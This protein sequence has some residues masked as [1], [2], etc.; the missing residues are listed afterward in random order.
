MEIGN[1]P[2]VEAGSEFVPQEI[3]RVF[4]TQQRLLI[5]AGFDSDLDM[6]VPHVR[7]DIHQGHR[8]VREA[9]VVHLEP[10]NLGQ[11]FFNGFRHSP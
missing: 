9:R 1:A 10:D 2:Q 5:G 8:D 3:L 7:R 4:Q 11:F 6:R